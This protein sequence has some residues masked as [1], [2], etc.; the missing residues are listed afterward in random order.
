MAMKLAFSTL[1]CPEWTWTEIYTMAYDLGFSGIEIRGLGEEIMAARAKPFLH[2][3]IDRT[4]EMLGR[5]KLSISCFSSNCVL[6]SPEGAQTADAEINEYIALA[7]KVGAPYVRVLADANPAPE[8]EVDD[9][10]VAAILKK[11]AVGAGKMNVTL[12]VETNGA[13]AD[14]KRLRKLLDTVASPYVAA[15]WD[16]HHPYRYFH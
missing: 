10:S 5:L 7:A 15:L 2:G 8:G 12:L 13:Y 1:G 6:A 16:V 9:T 3:E 4:A 11:L 14:T